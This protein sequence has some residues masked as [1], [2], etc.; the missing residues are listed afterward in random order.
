[1]RLAALIIFSTLA[2]AL[3]VFAQDLCG[4]GYY[5]ADGSAPCVKCPVGTFNPYDGAEVCL[6]CPMG[7]YSDVTGSAACTPCPEGTIAPF[8][9]SSQC[10]PC[11]EGT[12]PNAERTECVPASTPVEPTTWGLLKIRYGSRAD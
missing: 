3:A 4:P 1:M 7:S 6:P 10:Q 2:I 12:V 5:S 8:V 11:P 9:G